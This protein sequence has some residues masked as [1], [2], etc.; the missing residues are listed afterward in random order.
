MASVAT[1]HGAT[2][3][4]TDSNEL[5]YVLEGKTQSWLN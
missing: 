4:M 5:S 1:V 2:R 3:V